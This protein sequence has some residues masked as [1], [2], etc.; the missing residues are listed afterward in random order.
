M[1][2]GV[3]ILTALVV[4]SLLLWR[5]T[6]FEGTSGVIGWIAG[7]ILFIWS[8]VWFLNYTT[9]KGSIQEFIAIKQT[10]AEQR[11]TANLIEG[12]TLTV[13]I[14]EENVWLA[15]CKYWNGTIFGDQVPDE[16]MQLEPI[17]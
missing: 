3:V 15:R 13:K 7:I 6:E 1:L 12:A 16:V 4:G 9:N 10:I 5:F 2:I 8:C 17:K 11:Q 14:A